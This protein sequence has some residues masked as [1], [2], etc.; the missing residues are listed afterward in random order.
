MRI[1]AENANRD[2]FKGPNNQ[3]GVLTGIQ[4]TV[5]ASKSAIEAQRGEM[6]FATNR[7]IPTDQTL[8]S[9]VANQQQFQFYCRQALIRLPDV[10]RVASFTTEIVGDTLNYQATIITIFSPEGVS[11]SGSI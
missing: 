2:L 8:W 6:Q 10:V 7:G 4:A 9:G 11:L 1:L 5:Q 3:L